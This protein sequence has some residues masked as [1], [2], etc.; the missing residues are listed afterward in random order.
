M[1]RRRFALASQGIREICFEI[2]LFR[3]GRDDRDAQRGSGMPVLSVGGSKNLPHNNLSLT[4]GSFASI[5]NTLCSDVDAPGDRFH[6]EHVS[7]ALA[8]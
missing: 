8:A 4:D 2:R 7:S 3:D 5:L 1:C 6:T